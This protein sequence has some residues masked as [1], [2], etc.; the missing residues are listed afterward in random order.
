MKEKLKEMLEMM[1]NQSVD[2]NDHWSDHGHYDIDSMIKHDKTFYRGVLTGLVITNQISL[3]EQKEITI[4]IME[5]LQD[6]FYVD[7]G[8]VFNE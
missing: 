4:R 6:G 3:S 5:S 1:V 7:L 8:D 2:L